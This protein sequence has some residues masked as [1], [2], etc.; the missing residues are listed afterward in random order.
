MNDGI[1]VINKMPSDRIIKIAPFKKEVRVTR[2]HTHQSYLEIIFL[3][4]A[5]GYHFIDSK[6]YQVSPPVVF[7]VRKEQV[8]HWNMVTEP[9]GY[10][11]I[12]KE[13][14]VELTLDREIRALLHRFNS[15]EVLYPKQTAAIISLFELLANESAAG[16]T[17]SDLVVEGLLKALLA[18]LL[19]ESNSLVGKGPE[20]DSYR[21]FQEMLLQRDTLNNK[22]SHYASLLNTTPQNLNK[23]CRR[24]ANL[25]ASE[26]LSGFIIAEAKRLLIYTDKTISE[27]GFLLGFSDSSHFGKYFRRFTGMTPKI[28]RTAQQ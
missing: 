12:I 11:M 25:S 4:K 15:T 5:Q 20:T 24:A 6:K 17:I 3:S 27:I 16:I 18:K 19:P 2:P 1:S 26:V 8:H 23:V 21:L 9:E 14:F 13:K 7:F 10:V 28:F 22:V